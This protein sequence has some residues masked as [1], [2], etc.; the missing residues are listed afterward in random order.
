MERIVNG[1]AFRWRVRPFFIVLFMDLKK[2][3][4]LGTFFLICCSQTPPRE[5]TP[6]PTAPRADR[7]VWGAHLD[8]VDPDLQVEIRAVYM[9][10]EGKQTYADSGA[11]VQFR[12]AGGARRSQ[13]QAQRLTLDRAK[14]QITAAGEVLLETRDSLSVRAD[15]LVWNREEEEVW[16]PDRVEIR[17]PQGEEEGRGLRT[18]FDFQQWS[19]EAVAGR[20]TSVREGQEYEVSISAPRAQG[21]YLDGYVEVD[22]DSAAVR[23]RDVEL[24]SQRARYIE[25]D[26]FMHFS[27]GVVG[28]DSL[29]HFTA[30]ALDYDL[31]GEQA[32]A[33]GQVVWHQGEVELHADVLV[34]DRVAQKVEA[35]GQ[36]AQFFQGERSVAAAQLDYTNDPEQVVASGQVVY[37]QGERELRVQHLI[38]RISQE[39]L[40][41]DGAAVLQVPEF[42]GEATAGRLVFDLAAEEL[43]LREDPRLELRRAQPLQIS[44]EQ[45]HF[46]LQDRVLVGEPD[47]RL[48][49]GDLDLEAQ[50]GVYAEADERLAVAGAVKLRQSAVSYNSRLEADS[51]VVLLPEGRVTQVYLQGAFQGDMR[52]QEKQM[53]WMKS[54]RGQLFFADQ[55]LQRIELEGAADM[56]HQHLA[57]GSVSG[58][59]GERMLLFFAKGVLEQVEVLGGAEVLS[60]PAQEEG[61]EEFTPSHFRGEKIEVKLENGEVGQVDIV[62]PAGDIYAPQSEE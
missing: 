44:A 36:P 15:T 9:W 40:E 33:R 5:E 23:Y 60:R 1:R 24:R 41:A 50:R 27:G 29:R 35:R 17:T 37:R 61:E 25:A 48:T 18:D 31:G 8:I 56:T 10:V 58:F 21:R 26:G 6:A 53:V 45:L 2:S 32:E 39:D 62:R 51:M 43:E 46:D 38:Y 28:V 49:A 4:L 7:E 42:S 52:S 20:W 12:A 22:Y 11:Q 13:L 47:F 57:R 19:I 34:Q 30:T 16:I 54:E 55:R 3:L 59:K 14:T